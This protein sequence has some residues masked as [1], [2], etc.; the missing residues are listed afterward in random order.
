M[1]KSEYARFGQS[2]KFEIAIRWIADAEPPARRPF[3]HGW[4]M[5]HVEL[6]VAGVNLTASRLGNER[7]QYVGWYLAPMFDWLATNWVSLFHEEGF[8]WPKKD[9]APAAIACRR[10]LNFWIGSKDESARKIFREIQAWYS[11]HG[12]QSAAVGGLF[13]DLFIRRFADDIELSWSG[14]PPPFGPEGLIFESGAGIS[15]LAVRDVAEPLWKA[16]NWVKDN[17]PTLDASFVEN[18][19]ALCKKVDAIEHLGVR[20][21]ESAAVVEELLARVHASFVRVNKM[22]LLDEHFHPGRPFIEA[23]SPA[24]AMFGGL[25]PQLDD[26][27]V[28]ALRDALVSGEGGRDSP[29]LAALVIRRS[30]LPIGGVPHQDGYQ[31]AE[32]FLDDIEDDDFSDFSGR[33]YV[34]VRDICALLDIEVA[35]KSLDTD[36]IRGVALAGEGFRPMIVVNLTSVFNKNE[37]GRRFTIAHELCHILVDRTRARRI[38]HT[39]GPW[40]APSIEKRANAFAAYLLMPREMIRQSLASAA[41]I[42]AAAIRDLSY[43]LRVS[44]TAL[45]EHLYNLDF[46]DEIQREELR[47][48]FRM[49]SQ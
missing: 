26:E 13:P 47:S 14:D 41:D 38:A 46:I 32:A 17:P 18:W 15:R 9:A 29:R 43:R 35:E 49:Q 44:E 23:L 22:E 34:A 42:E 48:A 16:L 31:L 45:V 40:A 21:F 24:V 1:K 8:S 19:E 5:G 11:R 37:D 6:T 36:S 7:Q 20:D 3:G 10:A 30:H 4:S 25:S 2:D 27:D 28:D 12:L 33:G 39:S